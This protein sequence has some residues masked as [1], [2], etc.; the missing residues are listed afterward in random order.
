MK[1]QVEKLCKELNIPLDET[2]NEDASPSLADIKKTHE[3][4]QSYLICICG[5]NR[6]NL[7]KSADRNCECHDTRCAPLACVQHPPANTDVQSQPHVMNAV[8]LECVTEV[9]E[10]SS[11]FATITS[12]SEMVSNLSVDNKDT[13]FPGRQQHKEGPVSISNA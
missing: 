5:P 6:R 10:P 11:S 4:L 9:T 1:E 8:S 7:H 3:T 12:V 13:G 2:I